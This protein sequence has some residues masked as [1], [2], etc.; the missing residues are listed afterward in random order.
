MPKYH[1]YRSIEIDASPEEVFDVV[2]DFSKWTTWSPWL[3][4]EPDA[5]VTVTGDPSSLD[6]AYSWKGEVVG[7]GEMEHKKLE[8]GTLIE[9]EL[10]FIKPFKSR[11]DVWFDLEPA[12]GGTKITWHMRGSLPWFLFWMTSMM[13]VYIGM[14]YERGLRMLKEWIE[15]G[16][17][18]SRTVNKGIQSVGPIRMAGIRKTCNLKEIGPQ[19]E[20]ALCEA[21][22]KINQ[23]GISTDEGVMTVYHTANLK[24]GVFDFT[25]G[26]I[27]PDSA[28]PPA[29]LST[30]SI[31]TMKALCL[32]HHGN[33][34]HLGNAWSSAHQIARYRKYKQAKVGTFEIYRNDPEQTPPAEI[35]TDVYMPL[36]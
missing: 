12:A 29:D 16:E 20:S 22:E 6:A 10:R 36:R 31:P 17:I 35:H 32:E 4:A 18:L 5:E 19:M 13:E 7:Q 3:C 2:A 30:W 1:V 26:I 27:L 25:S 28:E 15:T 23:H 14:D 34:E 21:A 33:Y 24:T 9:N 11:S 8:R